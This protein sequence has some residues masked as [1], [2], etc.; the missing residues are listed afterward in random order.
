MFVDKALQ[1][2]NAVQ[3]ISRLNRI[4]PGKKFDTLTVDFTNSYDKI[5]KAFKKYQSN[6]E[7]HKEANPDDL[8][9]IKDELLKRGI[10]TLEDLDDCVRL[11]NSEND[12]DNAPLSA[13]LTK[14]KG[15]LQ[16]KADSEKQ[17]EFRTLLARYVSLFGF[18]RALFRLRFKDKILI[19][20]H[21]LASLLFKKLDPTMSTE[22]LE[23]EIAKVKL[24][25]FDIEKITE[26]TQ[27]PD[28]RDDDDEGGN[29]GGAQTGGNVTNVRPMTTVE[30]V[31]IAINL[32][33]KERVSPEGVTV[34]E[35]YLQAIQ[36]DTA[37]K[38]AIKNNLTGDER[39]VYDL[40]IK[41]I[42]DK[43]YTDYIINHSPQNYTE[44]TQENVQG[45]INHSAYKM[46][47]EIMRTAA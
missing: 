35:N 42:M 31:V 11:F 41:G 10:F 44:L 46:L 12:N 40:V 20:F 47:R 38:T 30:E 22:D 25:T 18:I 6:V 39:Q 24:K 1:D 45:F 7:S 3:T 15:I 2:R 9:K 17:R 26:G 32:R 36:Q 14:I 5:I 28:G 16:A 43:L 34:V 4:Y 29:G 19:D 13:L 8:Y 23:A 37:V 33:F 21:I 27:E